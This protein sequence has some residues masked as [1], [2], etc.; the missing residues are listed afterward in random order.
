MIDKSAVPDRIAS[1]GNWA[2][3]NSAVRLTAFRSA[4]STQGYFGMKENNPMIA[5]ATTSN[6]GLI[7]Y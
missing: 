7:L 4:A 5:P 2:K 6:A 1:L 3:G